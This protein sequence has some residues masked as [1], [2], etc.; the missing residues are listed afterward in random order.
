MALAPAAW[1]AIKLILLHGPVIFFA[2]AAARSF[3]RE[4][5]PVAVAAMLIYFLALSLPPWLGPISYLRLLA[6]A[7]AYGVAGV[8]ISLGEAR[9]RGARVANPRHKGLIAD[10]IALGGVLTVALLLAALLVTAVFDPCFEYDPFTYQLY[11]AATW[12][13]NGRL[14]I[15]P[16][17]FG[18]PSQAYGPALAS[19]AYL[20]LMAPLGTDLLAQTGQWTFLLLTVLAAAGLARECGERAG[21][22]WP[23]SSSSW[24]RSPFTRPG[25]RS[26]T[27]R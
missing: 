12:L 8:V 27:W 5:L 7:A 16:T 24:R 26:P 20:W 2:I 9:R 13:R 4:R 10:P 18:D 21:P 1:A 6:W 19:V 3:C 11:F 14:S 22:G 15:V 25:A 23:E 17:A